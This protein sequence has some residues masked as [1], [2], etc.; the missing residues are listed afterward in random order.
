MQAE[1]R[2]FLFFSNKNKKLKKRLDES[3]FLWYSLR[4]FERC[5]GVAQLVEQ[6]ICNQQVGGSSPS[7]SS[8]QI[9]MGRFPSGQREQTVNLPSTT[10]MVRIH[11]CP[12]KKRLLSTRAKGVFLRL[13]IPT[14]KAPFQKVLFHFGASI[15]LLSAAH[16]R[17]CFSGSLFSADAPFF[18]RKVES[19]KKLCY[20]TSIY[21][22]KRSG[23]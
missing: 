15:S 17:I 23:E 4:A 19:R 9:N 12:P 7:T 5:A 10:S 14:K 11:P 6:L 1:L 21:T 2:R 13:K 20:N 3:K 16:R 8:T 22:L 18:G